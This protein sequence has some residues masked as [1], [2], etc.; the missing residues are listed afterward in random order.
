MPATESHPNGQGAADRPFDAVLCDVDGVIRHL[1]STEVSRLERAAGLPEG[2]TASVGYAPEND[3][4]LL[5]GQI[6]RQEW[7][8][9]IVRDLLPRVSRKEAEALALAF[10]VADFRTDETVVGLLRHVREHCP[11]VLVSNATTWLDEDLAR[12]GLTGLAHSVVNSSLVGVSKPDRRIYEIAAERAGVSPD[13]CLF[14]DDR[15][16][17]VD[18]AVALGMTGV[19]HRTA[20]DLRAALG[21]LGGPNGPK[22]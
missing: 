15:Q 8:G 7:A 2:T 20:D 5:L 16:E 17:N 10:T 9:S 14:V 19:L 18:A 3:L 21:E 22:D 4:P 13:R 6:T 12:L 11:L 1:D